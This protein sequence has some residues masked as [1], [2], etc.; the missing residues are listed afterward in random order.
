MPASPSSVADNDNAEN[1]SRM[2]ELSTT[3][4]TAKKEERNSQIAYTFRVLIVKVVL[5]GAD[6]VVAALLLLDF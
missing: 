2:S 5:F 4:T 6:V 3:T 1:G